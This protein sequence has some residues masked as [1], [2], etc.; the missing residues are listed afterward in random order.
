MFI[1]IPGLT[2][3]KRRPEPYIALGNFDATILQE[4]YNHR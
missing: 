1:G 3:S 4:H 2:L